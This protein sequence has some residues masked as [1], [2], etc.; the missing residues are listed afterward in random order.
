MWYWDIKGNVSLDKEGLLQHGIGV[1][2]IV[3]RPIIA[4]DL[5]IQ[6]HGGYV[7]AAVS[8]TLTVDKM[9]VRVSRPRKGLGWFFSLVDRDIRHT[10]RALWCCAARKKMA[11]HADW[12]IFLWQSDSIGL[13]FQPRLV[14]VGQ[15]ELEFSTMRSQKAAEP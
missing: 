15:L 2:Q 5:A 9:M 4:A 10:G 13:E 11:A 3:V 7:W 14:S 8:N 6:G 1:L 12:S